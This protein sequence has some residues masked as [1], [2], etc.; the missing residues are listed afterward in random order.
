ML[1]AVG[2]ELG[3]VYASG[4][5]KEDCLRKLNELYPYE[6]PKTL[7]GGRPLLEKGNLYPEP[8]R[9]KRVVKK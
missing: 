3:K 8:L 4:K 5:Y 9:I 6:R 1:V 7:T 2:I